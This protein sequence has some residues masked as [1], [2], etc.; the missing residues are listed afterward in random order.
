MNIAS[1]DH[2]QSR[3]Q[4]IHIKYSTSYQPSPSAPSGD[5]RATGEQASFFITGHNHKDHSD[6]IRYFRVVM[7]LMA[8]QT[9]HATG[10]QIGGLSMLLRPNVE[11][12]GSEET[13]NKHEEKIAKNKPCLRPCSMWILSIAISFPTTSAWDNPSSD[14]SIRT[15]RYP[16]TRHSS[17]S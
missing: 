8:R 4:S 3:G 5:G 6:L 16:C 2:P 17:P 1:P 12:A 13:E 10:V 14:R 11:L 15:M 9:D 7:N